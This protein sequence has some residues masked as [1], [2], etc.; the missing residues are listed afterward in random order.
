M[1]RIDRNSAIR[2]EGYPSGEQQN[3]V[4]GIFKK[5]TV[6][7]QW[8]NF[9]RAKMHFNSLSNRNLTDEQTETHQ[10]LIDRFNSRK[11]FVRCPISETYL[12]GCGVILK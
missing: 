12:S 8:G 10:N 6:A 11:K 7:I 4:D 3:N 1:H 5:I 2:V 9:G